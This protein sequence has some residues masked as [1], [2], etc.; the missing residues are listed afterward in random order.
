MGCPTEIEIGDNLVFSICT[1]DPETGILTDADGNPTYRVYEDETA[2]PLATGT[3]AKLD[4]AN[5]T[6]FYT[7]SIACTAL[8]GYE[9]GKSYTIYIEAIVDTN[10]GGITLGFKAYDK[11]KVNVVSQDNIDFGVLQKASINAEVLDVLNVD[12]FAEPT[13]VP[14]ATSSLIDK[15]KWLFTLARNKIT[16][17]S[18]TSTLKNDAGSG[19]IGTS[20]V[21]D[22]A[23]TFTRGEWT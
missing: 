6:G 18:T 10:T 9:N 19:N 8:L 16:Q 23:T 13:A 1:H 2:T 12:T 5:T 7:E 20:T 14:A 3:M 11:R 21:S 22:D 17:T 4:D 15:I